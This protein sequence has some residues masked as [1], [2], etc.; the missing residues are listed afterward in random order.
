M[1]DRVI[2]GVEIRSGNKTPDHAVE[3]KEYNVTE[4]PRITRWHFNSEIVYFV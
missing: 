2:S 4:T 3:K 1:F